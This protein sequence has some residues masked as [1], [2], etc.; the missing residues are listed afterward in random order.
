[1]DERSEV[2]F[3]NVAV[4]IQSTSSYSRTYS[5][6]VK[7]FEAPENHHRY[8]RFEGRDGISELVLLVTRDAY[9]G[10]FLTIGKKKY[11]LQFSSQSDLELF[12]RS[13]ELVLEREEAV[14][15]R[16]KVAI[17]AGIAQME[18]VP[19]RSRKDLSKWRDDD[20]CTLPLDRQKA[21]ADACVTGVEE[22]KRALGGADGGSVKICPEAQPGRDRLPR[23][24]SKSGKAIPVSLL[25]LA[26]GSG[27]R[28][29]FGF[30]LTFCEMKPTGE[31]LRQAIASGDD[32]MVRDVWNRLDET[33]RNEALVTSAEVASEFGNTTV[34]RWLIDFCN[35]ELR[36]R[37]AKVVLEGHLVTGLI[38]LVEAGYRLSTMSKGVASRAMYMWPKVLTLVPLAAPV[39]WATALADDLGRL[40]RRGAPEPAATHEA[41]E[42][43]QSHAPPAPARLGELAMADRK[44]RVRFLASR[45][46]AGALP[47]AT[48]HCLIDMSGERG[49]RDYAAAAATG[50]ELRPDG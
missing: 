33:A 4:S 41:R 37:F 14:F 10:E 42:F 40:Y 17:M 5:G 20:S 48:W 25:E 23:E 21:I 15:E 45:H 35:A 46:T 50:S 38:A 3:Q 11:S 13:V 28:D 22:L 8:F 9:D 34:A 49:P 43:L 1:M 29:C 31:T 24:P 47:D 32:E 27:R 16:E 18:I 12:R 19:T 7:I 39:S 26:A 36:G 6:M 30:L 2:S 44:A